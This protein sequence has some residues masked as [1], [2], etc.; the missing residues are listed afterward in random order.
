MAATRRLDNVPGSAT[1]SATVSALEAGR[2]PLVVL[3]HGIP[4][5]ARLW[6][7]VM[8][9]LA[10]GGL[11]VLAPD[12]PGYGLTRVVSRGDHSL[13]AA[14]NLLATWLGDLGA[15]PAWVVG[16]DAGG[17]VAQ[18]LAV[19]HPEVVARLTLVNSIV[20]GSWPAP[21]A[22]IAGAAARLGLYRLGARLGLVPNPYIRRELRRGFADPT[23]AAE[24]DMEAVFWADKT[25]DDTSRRAFEHH[26]VALD[27]SDTAR[28]APRLD[29]LTVPCQL[30]WGMADPFQTWEVAGQRLQDL[31]PEPAVTQLHGCGHLAPLE[32][33]DE[34]VAA[35]E[36]WR[37]GA[38][39]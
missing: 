34:L 10:A 15:G 31:L 5:S 38:Q 3:L 13:T 19:D 8:G 11:R 20:D 21:R 30:L 36:E 18:L 9:P 28:V 32:C 16:H 37:G 35:L 7:P 24:V 33:P 4:S 1:A 25:A 39:W 29:G 14:A 12:L 2:G 26:L 27:P 23:R 6:E 22:R 17:A